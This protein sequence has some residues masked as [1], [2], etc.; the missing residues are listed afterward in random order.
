MAAMLE[1]VTLWLDVVLEIILY[2]IC[3]RFLFA[4]DIKSS[5]FFFFLHLMHDIGVT[6][7]D[8]VMGK[9]LELCTASP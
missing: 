4:V 3:Y 6:L 7:R 2:E 1:F 9:G 5:F 8:T